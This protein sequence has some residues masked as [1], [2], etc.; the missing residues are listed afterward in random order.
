MEIFDMPKKK[1][2]FA[3]LSFFM[4]ATLLPA[5]EVDDLRCEGL[6]DPLGI[7]VARPRLS[8]IIASDG[9]GQRQT[10]YQVLAAKSLELLARDQGDLWDSGKV[11]SD[12]STHVEYAGKSLAARARC[13]WKVRVW[14]TDCKASAWSAP[15]LWTMGLLAPGD[16]QGKWIGLDQG[17]LHAGDNPTA[18]VPIASAKW[19][20]FPEGNPAMQR[21]SAPGSSGRL[22]RFPK[23]HASAA[24]AAG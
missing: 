15:A 4:L 7:D 6:A 2:P 24:H 5:A 21:R 11:P 17:E 20:W 12:Q 23:T 9:R 3:L 16:W 10:A 14:D 1:M 22:S 13:F 19:I 8:W 18:S